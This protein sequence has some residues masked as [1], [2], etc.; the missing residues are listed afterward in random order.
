MSAEVGAAIIAGAGLVISIVT[1][2][3][4]VAVG[5]GRLQQ[6]VAQLELGRA[7]LATKDDVQRVSDQVVE[8]RGM[9]RLVLR[10]GSE[11]A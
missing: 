11:A 7:Q 4:I 1:S 6:R 8:I 9:F 3:L 10:D 2:L 5:Y